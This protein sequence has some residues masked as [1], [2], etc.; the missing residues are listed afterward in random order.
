MALVLVWLQES[1]CEMTSWLRNSRPFHKRVL[2][3]GALGLAALLLLLVLSQAAQATT[4][5]VNGTADVIANDGVCTLREAITAANTDTASGATPGECPAGSGADTINVPDNV[6]NGIY[7]LTIANVGGVP[8]DGN[9]SGDL[10]ITS[11]VTINGAGGTT[12]IQACD[13]SGGPCTG[14]ERVFDIFASSNVTIS[15]V[16]VQNGSYPAGTGGGIVN[17]GTLALTDSTVMNNSASVAGG[18]ANAG[19]LTPTNSTV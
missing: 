15:G 3:S 13:S 16:T 14:A 9:A 6:P 18:I 19:T 4:I 10:D 1:R 8:E 11:D 5:A 12:I 7:T 17:G 2:L